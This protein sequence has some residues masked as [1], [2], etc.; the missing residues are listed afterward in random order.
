LDSFDI[1]ENIGLFLS[2][3]LSK[4]D[5][6]VWDFKNKRII[7]YEQLHIFLNKFLKE[8]LGISNDKIVKIITLGYVGVMKYVRGQ[9]EPKDVEKILQEIVE[10][11]PTGTLN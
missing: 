9:M 4:N 8:Y 3:M 10:L 2:Q 11:D 1:D 7:G 5:Q 6:Y